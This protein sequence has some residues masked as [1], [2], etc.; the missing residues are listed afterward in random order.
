MKIKYWF[1]CIVICGLITSCGEDIMVENMQ[2]IEDYLSENNI[3]A[4]STNS[5]LYYVINNPGIGDNPTVQ[6]T[7]TVHYHG[8]FTNGQV[9]DSSIDRGVPLE[10]PLSNV[11]QGW[12]EGIQLFKRGGTGHL[13]IPSH[14][15]YGENPPSGIPKNAVL[16]FDVELIDFN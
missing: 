6:N 13:F 11:I 2:E 9:F 15:A 16:I 7:V 12:Q 8:Y 4:Q 10:I 1:Y 3:T 5:G 14:L